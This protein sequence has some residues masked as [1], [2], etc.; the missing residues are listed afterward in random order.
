MQLML[1]PSNHMVVHGG[2][3]W[4]TAG[5]WGDGVGEYE[6]PEA[7]STAEESGREKQS[8]EKVI[9]TRAVVHGEGNRGVI[10]GQAKKLL[11][12]C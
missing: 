6:K 12:I 5:G 10:T 7:K 11:S 8:G 9:S 1:L 4:E 3:H 2:C